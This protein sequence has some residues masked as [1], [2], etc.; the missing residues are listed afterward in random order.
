MRPEHAEAILRGF[1]DVENCRVL[2]SGWIALHCSR[3]RATQEMKRYVEHL[4]PDIS[5][6]NLCS[7]GA[8]VGFV[9]VE[10]SVRLADLRAEFSCM[11]PGADQF[12]QGLRK[13]SVD[14]SFCASHE[15]NCKLSP[16]ATGSVCNILSKSIRLQVPIPCSGNTGQW[17]LPESVRI[18]L[19]RQ[20][21]ASPPPAVQDFRGTQA[22]SL[23]RQWPLPWLPVGIARFPQ[24]RVRKR[25]R[26]RAVEKPVR[27][28]KR[29]F[30]FL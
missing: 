20:M 25:Q 13:N 26:S 18:Q 4:L 6:W 8:I 23:P 1:K 21:T 24:K 16:F 10:R 27:K 15:E 28:K 7:P 14:L 3:T 2:L 30:N 29:S 19:T 9:Y 22:T 5:T 12:M 11:C 17:S